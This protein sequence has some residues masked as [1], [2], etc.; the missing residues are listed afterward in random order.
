MNCVKLIE[1]NDINV[2]LY[3]ESTETDKDCEYT[4]RQHLLDFDGSQ[5]KFSMQWINGNAFHINPNTLS[6]IND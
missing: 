1:Y 5:F 2:L 3:Q 6:K 4:D